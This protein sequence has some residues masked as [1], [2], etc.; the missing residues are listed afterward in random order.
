MPGVT[1]LYCYEREA[2][3]IEDL[4][5]IKDALNDEGYEIDISSSGG[6]RR[7]FKI[8]RSEDGES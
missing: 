8:T 6:G 7:K 5:R 2:A 3:K 1:V 4:T